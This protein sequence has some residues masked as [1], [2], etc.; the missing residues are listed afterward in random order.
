MGIAELAILFLRASRVYYPL[1]MTFPVLLSPSTL[2]T[3]FSLTQF[4]VLR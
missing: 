3:I 4:K 2:L 1:S